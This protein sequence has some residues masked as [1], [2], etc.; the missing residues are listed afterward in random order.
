M[1]LWRG[2]GQRPTVLKR[3]E[4]RGGEPPLPIRE[5]DQGRIGST[6]PASCKT[7]KRGEGESS[8]HWRLEGET[9]RGGSPRF[10]KRSL[11][12]WQVFQYIRNCAA[13]N[14]AEAR[15]DG[16]VYPLKASR[17]NYKKIFS[18]TP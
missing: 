3:S 17:W 2:V 14:P 7:S 11:C 18:K 13:E 16:E 12:R 4:A 1:T 5:S 15:K 8:L 10:R 6:Q 9:P